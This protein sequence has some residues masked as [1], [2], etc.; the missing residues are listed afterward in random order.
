MDHWPWESDSPDWVLADGSSILRLYE[1]DIE[2]R[3]PEVDGVGI[4]MQHVIKQIQ[5]Q[6]PGLPALHWAHERLSNY[7][8]VPELSLVVAG[9]MCGRVALITMTRPQPDLSFKRGFKVEAILPTEK[10]EDDRLRPVCPLFGVAVGPL[11]LGS[12]GTP[13]RISPARPRR[14]RLM[15]QYYDLRILSYEISRGAP[16]D[17]LSIA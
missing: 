11:P 14:Y 5:P 9:S 16:S 7:H 10:D 17:D 6:P 1:T 12:S 4:M 2:L 13:D 3:S 8:Y 15:L